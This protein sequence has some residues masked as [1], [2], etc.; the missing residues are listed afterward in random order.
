MLV[1]DYE[2][3]QM[4]EG[5][6]VEEMFA[7]FNKIISDLKTFGKP[8]SSGDQVQKILRSVPTTWQIKVVALESQDLNKLSYAELRGNLIA[9]V[10]THLKKT[11][12]EEKKKIVTFKATTKRTENDI[13]DDPN[14]LEDEIAMVSRNMDGLMRRYRNTR[15]E[16]QKM[17]NE[18]RR[19]NREKKY[20]ELKLEVC[21]IEK[22]GRFENPK[23]IVIL[24]E[25]TNK[26]P[27]KLGYLKQSD[28]SIVLEHHRKSRKGKLY[29]D[30][31]RF[32][33]MTSDKNLFKEVTKINGGSVKLAMTQKER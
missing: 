33:H 13:D 9:F 28:N 27:S 19:L 12:R 21:E 4:K 10:K 32:S 6:P 15:K 3:F 18:L 26:D 17:M 7:R 22:E 16:S 30:S 1:H 20:R 11:S 8:Y 14:A 2:L 23:T 29:L 5:E 25:L 31:A 24:V